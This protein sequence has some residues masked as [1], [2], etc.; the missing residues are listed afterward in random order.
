MLVFVLSRVE[1]M[2]PASL[3]GW[4]HA[5]QCARVEGIEPPLSVLET[6]VLPL[7]D[8]RMDA[9]VFIRLWRAI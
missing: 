5:K 1:G 3:L 2:S 6:D 8:T 4:R 9:V 7:Y